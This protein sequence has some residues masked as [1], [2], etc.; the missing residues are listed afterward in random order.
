MDVWVSV[1]CLFPVS[2]CYA[3]APDMKTAAGLPA[4]RTPR[5][6]GEI[7]LGL[8]CCFPGVQ[9]GLTLSVCNLVREGSGVVRD[10]VLPSRSFCRVG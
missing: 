10:G 8:G 2:G 7:L 3:L 4:P 9:G 6:T 5:Q 1:W